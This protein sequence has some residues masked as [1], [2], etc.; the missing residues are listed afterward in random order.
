MREDVDLGPYQLGSPEAWALTEKEGFL[1]R[2]FLP[3]RQFSDIAN[4][5]KTFL[6]GRRGSGKSAIAI[7]LPEYTDHAYKRTI[8]GE[9]DQYGAYLEIVRQLDEARRVSHES[10]DI[11]QAVHRLWA[12]VLPVMAMQIVVTDV[13]EKAGQVDDS[14]LDMESYLDSLAGSASQ[15][16][17]SRS[18]LGEHLPQGIQ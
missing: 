4:A 8:Q 5:D 16:L 12:W 6:C 13:R 10:L 17:Y 15:G 7:K 9:R 1:K 18:A 3:I 2:S 11:K 14:I